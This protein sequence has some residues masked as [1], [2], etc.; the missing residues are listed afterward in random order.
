MLVTR[1]LC[2][3]QKNNLTLWIQIPLKLRP[4]VGCKNPLQSISP[5]YM[6]LIDY[7]MNPHFVTEIENKWRHLGFSFPL[8][9]F[10]LIELTHMHITGPNIYDTYVT[11][12]ILWKRNWL[13]L[14]SCTMPFDILVNQKLYRNS[15]TT[16]NASHRH[17]VIILHYQCS[18]EHWR[19]QVLF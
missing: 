17:L 16:F 3:S 7:T 12:V 5:N 6:Y 14:S 13:K 15:E 8:N 1:D 4:P 2:H 18:T 19:F 11:V 10:T 9:F